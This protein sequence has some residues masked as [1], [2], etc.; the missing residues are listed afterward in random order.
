MTA[1]AL[2]IDIR[3]WILP[4]LYETITDPRD[5]TQLLGAI[6]PSGELCVNP[7]ISEFELTGIMQD[8]FGV[9]ED[10]KRVA[11][12][13]LNARTDMYQN[14]IDV[15]AING[16]SV[17]LVGDVITTALELAVADELLK[18]L[19]P[20][21]VLGMAGNVTVDVSNMLRTTTTESTVLDVIP[22]AIMG[23]NHYFEQ[24]D[25]YNEDEKRN[26]A[27]NVSTYWA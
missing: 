8:F 4:L 11:M 12:Q 14:M 3:A 19:Q 22:T 7:T 21:Q 18:P 27:L 23:E 1:I 24:P 16:R 15:H 20:S 9:I 2:A 17:V 13:R 5:E 6:T 26:L 10:R 25:A